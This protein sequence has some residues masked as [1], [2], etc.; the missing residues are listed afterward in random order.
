MEI[1]V[2]GGAGFI[3]KHLVQALMAAGH[4]TTVLDLRKPEVADHW[5]HADIREDLFEVVR[6]FDAVYHLAAIA[7]AIYAGQLPKKAYEINVLGTFNVAHACLKNE[8]PRLLYAST[9]WMSG[10]Q[11]GEKVTE[12]SPFELHQMNTVYGSTKLAGEMVLQSTF[13]E[14]RG[15]RYTIM[16]YGIPY[17]EGMNIGLVVREFMHQA[18]KFKVLTI[19]GDGNQ[20]R[21]FLYVGDLAEVQVRLLDEQAENK[22]YNLASERL[23]TVKELA[24]EVVEFFPAKITYIPQARVEPRIKDV[25]STA[26]FEDFGWRPD[27]ALSDGIARCVDWWGTVE[28]QEKDE[29]TYFVP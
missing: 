21:N 22:I 13:A 3:G 12:Y 26:A 8:I 19:F 16:R 14:Y 28:Q 24:E 4:R 7:N 20:G 2:T 27:T 11:V 23:I 9:T 15:P 25:R 6:G 29:G 5:I 10:L 1:L 17:G 18:E